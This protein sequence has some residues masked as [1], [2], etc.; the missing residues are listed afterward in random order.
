[1]KTESRELKFR[2]WDKLSK[3]MCIVDCL[4]FEFED[5]HKNNILAEVFSNK[6]SGGRKQ[7]F[8]ENLILMQFTGLKDST[9][10]EIY[11]DDICVINELSDNDF[12]GIVKWDID[13][14]VLKNTISLTISDYLSCIE[15]IGNI[16]QHPQLLEK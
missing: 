11:E 2:A 16:H 1:M 10:K 7:I 3:E 13:R 9:G 8:P 4:R 12:T 5:D 14:Y 15:I 6:A